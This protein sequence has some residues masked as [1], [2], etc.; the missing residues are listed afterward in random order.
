MAN[1]ASRRVRRDVSGVAAY[2]NPAPGDQG[3]VQTLGG[4]GGSSEGTA[5]AVTLTYKERLVEFTKRLWD[6]CAWAAEPVGGAA[7]SLGLAINLQSRQ[8]DYAAAAPWTQ[9]QLSPP[10]KHN[11]MQSPLGL[12][13]RWIQRTRGHVAQIG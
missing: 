3:G 1:C 5:D 11:Q 10:A 6:F 4:I 13:P 8:P 7:V 2:E 9:D 12:R